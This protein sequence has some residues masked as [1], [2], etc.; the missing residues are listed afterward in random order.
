MTSSLGC[1]ENSWC[2]D[3]I[4]EEEVGEVEEEVVLVAVVGGMPL[5]WEGGVRGVRGCSIQ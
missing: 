2:G 4:Q 1:W 5:T 3:N